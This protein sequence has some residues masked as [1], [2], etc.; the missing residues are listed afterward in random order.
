MNKS[1]PTTSEKRV[2][3]LQ[4]LALFI[5]ALIMVMIF[6]IPYK[7]HAQTFPSDAVTETYATVVHEP[8]ANYASTTKTIL[9]ISAVTNGNASDGDGI[10]L[11]CGG[12]Y[13]YQLPF[14]GNYKYQNEP[15][16]V[17]C[18]GD[19]YGTW[20]SDTGTDASISLTYVNRDI[21]KT[22]DPRE[23]MNLQESLT[24]ACVI[25]F[26]LAIIAWPAFFRMFRRQDP[27]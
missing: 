25:L 1:Q 2:W 14:V 6:G 12:N 21:T 26:F 9:Y 18:N 7:A 10:V 24:V 3:I 8:F 17:F 13:I 5:L 15:L 19:F 4:G 20:E 16:Q 11:W 22:S 27:I 23:P